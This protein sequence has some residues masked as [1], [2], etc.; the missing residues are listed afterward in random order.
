MI[1]CLH[2]RVKVTV[3]CAAS[4]SHS[5][6][7]GCSVFLPHM[8]PQ[9][10]LPRIPVLVW[11]WSEGQ[12]HVCGLETIHVVIVLGEIQTQK[13]LLC[14]MCLQMLLVA[15]P[16][17]TFL[18]AQHLLEHQVAH[19]PM[20]GG[21]RSRCCV[22]NGKDNNLSKRLKYF[23]LHQAFPNALPCLK[24]NNNKEGDQEREG[25]NENAKKLKVD[26]KPGHGTKQNTGRMK[27]GSN[28][29]LNL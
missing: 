4:I 8:D 28:N 13:R 17:F 15:Q 20:P 21:L 23:F 10:M 12:A 18:S 22:E 11:Q 7:E 14:F 26:L 25:E 19:K 27:I 1:A 16:C 5:L 6:E 24:I 3:L 9:Y 2:K 29:F